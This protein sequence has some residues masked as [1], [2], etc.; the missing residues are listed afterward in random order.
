MKKNPAGQ[1]LKKLQMEKTT[2]EQRRQFAAIAGR[3]SG[4]AR[5][6]KRA[7]AVVTGIITGRA[8]GK[9]RRA[10]REANADHQQRQ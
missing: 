5:R 3:A 1:A 6:A 8:S 4:K 10:K 2:P 9:A 7:I